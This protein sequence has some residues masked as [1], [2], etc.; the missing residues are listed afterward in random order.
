MGVDNF[1]R[2]S[3]TFENS[4]GENLLQPPQFKMEIICV[5]SGFMCDQVKKCAKFLIS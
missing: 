2:S 3:G 1:Q 5:R 4:F